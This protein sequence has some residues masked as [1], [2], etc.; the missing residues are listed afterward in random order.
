MEQEKEKAASERDG[1][2]VSR[3]IKEQAGYGITEAIE[4]ECSKKWNFCR[5]NKESKDW[6]KSIRFVGY[7]TK[8]PVIFYKVVS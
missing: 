7:E 1:R 6:N 4:G 2:E 8:L 5:D 3:K